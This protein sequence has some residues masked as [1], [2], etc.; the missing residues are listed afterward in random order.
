VRFWDASAIVP[1]LVAESSTRRLQALIARDSAMLVWWTSEI[2]CV[3]AV[4]RLERDGRLNPNA[5]A[6]HSS[7]SDSLWPVGKRSIQ[8]MPFEKRRLGFF[9]CIRYALSTRCNLLLLFSLR[10]GGPHHWRLLRLTIVLPWRRAK[11]D[12]G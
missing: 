2:E 8:A 11:K 4:A 5:V 7:V 1:L 3:S 10:S 12:S 6:L 9:A